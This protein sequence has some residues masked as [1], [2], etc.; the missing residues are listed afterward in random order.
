MGPNLHENTMRR[1]KTRGLGDVLQQQGGR[2]TLH[3]EAEP[4]R[5]SNFTPSFAESPAATR[6]CLM[7]FVQHARFF[8]FFFT[9]VTHLFGNIYSP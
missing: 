5:M 1:I 8:F 6:S 7:V 3:V 4:S 2:Q 9:T